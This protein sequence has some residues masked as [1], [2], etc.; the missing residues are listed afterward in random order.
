[1]HFSEESPQRLIFRHFDAPRKKMICKRDGKRVVIVN[2]NGHHTISSCKLKKSLACAR[3]SFRW[4][5]CRKKDG[6]DKIKNNF[7]VSVNFDA[8]DL[9]I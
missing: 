2:F 9:Y 4:R 1:M 7:S 8:S 6:Y 5:H 3:A